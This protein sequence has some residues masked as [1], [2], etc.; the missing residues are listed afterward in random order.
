[1]SGSLGGAPSTALA[2]TSLIASAVYGF[3]FLQRPP[4]PLRTLAKT[5]A[6]GA[7]AAIAWISGHVWLLAIGFSLSALGDAFLA[8]DPKRW[9]PLGLISFL[10]AH[11]A[12]VVVFVHGG[13]GVAMFRTEVIRIA[14]LLGCV[15]GAVVVFRL[16]MHKLGPMTGPVVVYMLA[17]VAMVFTAFALPWSRWPAMAGAA[18]FLVSDG[19]LAVRLFKYDGRPNL[20]ADLGVWWLYY[21]AQVGIAAAFLR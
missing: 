2:A 1:M 20:T 13:G 6:V 17:I 14:A 4:S 10:L 5:L 7:I 16:I 15:A 18:C 11:A 8:G 12:Y 21:A 3:W 19:V 9:L